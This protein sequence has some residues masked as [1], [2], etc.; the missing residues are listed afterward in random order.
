MLPRNDDEEDDRIYL[1]GFSRGAFTVRVLAG[2]IT[3]SGLYTDFEDEEDLHREA[4]CNYASYRDRY[5][6]GYLSRIINKLTGCKMQP[7]PT[8]QPSIQ[9]IGVWDTVDAYV[10]PIDELAILWDFL[11]YP[12]RFPDS[13]LN[14]KVIRACHAVSIDDE[15]HTFHP[16]MWD[17]SEE[18]TER[19][20]QVWFPGVHADVGGGYSKRS[21]SLVA[22][23]WMV[24]Q[25]EATVVDQGLVYIKDL[26]E[27]YKSKSD[28]NGPQH[29]SR[30]GLATYYRYKPRSI[31]HICNDEMPGS[32]SISP[33]YT[34]V[35]S[36][37]SRAGLYLMLLRRYPL[38]TKLLLQKVMR[39]NLRLQQ[40][41]MSVLRR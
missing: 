2:F 8:I 20:T 19:I 27:Q 25:T 23:D 12:I 22:L 38:N 14:E 18:T 17:E 41:L 16:V 21:L 5:K 6:R 26:R 7:K 33:R 24:T 35:C 34:V 13:K 29:D 1:F 11:V 37:V 9:F 30:S 39:Q 10:F 15:R 36:N 32:R 4:L 40:R 28:W 3:Y 31:S